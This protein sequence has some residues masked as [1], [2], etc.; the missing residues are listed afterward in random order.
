VFAVE[1]GEQEQA[2]IRQMATDRPVYA[3]KKAK[4][5]VTPIMTEIKLHL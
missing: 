1:W 3:G 2:I 5:V 4:V